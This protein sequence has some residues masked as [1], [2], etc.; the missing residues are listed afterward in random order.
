M[1][2]D[3]MLTLAPVLAPAPLV[4]AAL[5][6][7]FVFLLLGLGA[8]AVT[9]ALD[10]AMGKERALLAY[11]AAVVVFTAVVLRDRADL[12]G[13]PP[14]PR[15]DTVLAGFAAK[16]TLAPAP[17]ARPSFESGGRDRRNPYER[18]SDTRPLPPVEIDL[19]PEIALEVPLPPTVPGLAPS[20][21]R[22]LRGTL[23]AL[24]PNDA[25]VPLQVAP[26]VFEQYVP[27][28]EDVYDWVDVGGKQTFVAIVAIDG[29]RR[30]ESGFRALERRLAGG[31]GIDKM[32]VEWAL[33]G[34]A[35]Q[36]TK[37]GL[38]PTSVA[39]KSKGNRNTD[40]A[41]KF[42]VWNLRRTVENTYEQAVR[43]V[44]GIE[45]VE[46][47]MNLRGL[48][49]A[50]REMAVLGRTGKEQREGW[51][52]AVLLLERA[53]AV[54][55]KAHPPEVQAEVLVSLVEAYNAL[56]DEQAAL[57]ALS[58]YAKAVP[59]RAEPWI[60]LGDAA[61]V[62]MGLPDQSLAY[63]TKAK[64]LE[65]GNERVALGL[66][67]AL[68]ALGRDRDAL[69]AYGRAGASFDAQ[70]RRAEAALRVGELPQARQAADAALAQ[71][72]D[73]PRALL[74]R[75]GVL[76]ALGDLAGAKSAYAMAATSAEA[77]GAWRAQAL[78]N[79][80]LCHWRLCETRAA[81]GAFEACE[82]ALRQGASPGRRDDETVSP[83]LGRALIA[84][85]LKAP[86]P[87]DPAAPAADPAA[88]AAAALPPLGIEPGQAGQFLSAAREEAA[89]TSYLEHLAGVLATRAGN[90][91]AAIRAL[92]RSL[93]LA[94]DASEL[95]GWLAINHLRWGLETA[96]RATQ[97]E[98]GSSRSALGDENA[99]LDA[100]LALPSAEHHEAAVAFAS[101]AARA[102][103]VSAK[104]VAATLREAWVLLQAQ[105]LSARKR[106]ELAREA[107]DRI[108][109]R[110]DD[111]NL[112]EQPAALCMRAYASYRLGGDENYDACQQDL[113]LVLGKVPAAEEGQPVQPWAAWRTWADKTLTRVKHWRSLEEK[114]VS[115]EG[116]SQLTK[117]WVTA[118]RSSV[119]VSL[120]PEGGLLVFEGK[121]DK[122]GSMADPTV[123]AYCQAFFDKSTFEEVR[124]KLRIPTTQEDGSR[125]N[126]IFFGVGV[127]GATSTSG[128]G[129]GGIGGRHPGVLLCFEKGLVAAR[130]GTGLSAQWKE[131]N[132]ARVRDEAGN[133][134]AWPAG[135]WVEVR[136]VREDAREGLMAVYLNDEQVPVVSDKVSGF[137]GVSGKAE[138]WLGG[139]SPSA[140]PYDVKVK[141]IRV[142]RVR[143]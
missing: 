41:A 116:M 38:D 101:R 136:I 123:A 1:S 3:T 11:A 23:P 52:R 72:G 108:L 33:I 27:T 93:D 76:Y 115:F 117:E 87:A 7:F 13:P 125:A 45:P 26:V 132:V 59:T 54:A 34:S 86:P 111:R 89:R 104:T 79:L 5:G 67:D 60:R 47:T 129:A 124:L 112:L 98:A 85:A 106:F 96:G 29:V 16:R 94:P 82:L 46:A 135:E 64:G 17:M 143:K 6:T 51:R 70:V 134:R 133:E 100:I 130:I 2:L 75:G 62:G 37:A 24:D 103:G 8:L 114:V 88:V 15:E 39:K 68:T 127:Q 95:D 43:R 57:R 138:L 9:A 58:A 139:W 121:A 36:A 90:T 105:H 63:F 131:G 120:E 56:K 44:L 77:A 92:R 109:K 53:R 40:P 65:E 49:E 66:G 19:P 141:D 4:G 78:Y 69:A 14:R 137:K 50:A 99:R 31:E 28:P 20:A 107:C 81:A 18:V 80:G 25:S 30:G 128:A 35:E 126:N 83:S 118:E 55:E 91:A 48:Q 119:K 73:H 61:L 74:A 97:G 12:S 113:V 21:R 84:M 142:V 102:D 42:G 110:N 10:R 22:L 140:L 32:Q 122:D 71:R